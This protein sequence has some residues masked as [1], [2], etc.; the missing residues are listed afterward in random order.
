M[1][2]EVF[3]KRSAPMAGAP[4]VTLQ[5]RGIVSINGP[6]HALINRPRVVELL[7]DRERRIVAL[8]SADPSPTTYELRRP[9]RSGQTLLSAAAFTKAYDIDTDVSRRFEPFVEDG[10]LCF[11]LN[12]PS[13]EI[14]G[15]RSPRRDGEEST[16]DH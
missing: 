2:F 15:N 5:R 10:M 1:P 9:T 6:A 14:R 4:S 13:V 3:D 16:E 8:R 7:F 12:G 11:D